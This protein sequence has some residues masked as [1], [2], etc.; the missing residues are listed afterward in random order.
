[1]NPAL[2]LQLLTVL[3]TAVQ[4]GVDLYGI[5]SKAKAHLDSGQD[6]TAEEWQAINDEIAGLLK[7]L[8]ADPPL[9][10]V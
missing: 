6:P 8:D 3:P 4:A 5:A 9:T 10:A 2:I 7:Q 1:M